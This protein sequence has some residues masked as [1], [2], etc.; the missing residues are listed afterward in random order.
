MGHF[1]FG[2]SALPVAYAKDTKGFVADLW[3]S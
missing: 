1:K 2:G 3:S